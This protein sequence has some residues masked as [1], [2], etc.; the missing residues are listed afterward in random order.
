MLLFRIEQTGITL[1]LWSGARDGEGWRN[2]RRLDSNPAPQICWPSLTEHTAP[3][4]NTVEPWEHKSLKLCVQIKPC[5]NCSMRCWSSLRIEATNSFEKAWWHTFMQSLQTQTDRQRKTDTTKMQ[6]G[7]CPLLQHLVSG[8]FSMKHT[9]DAYKPKRQHLD[10]PIVQGS[11]TEE[12]ILKISM[13]CCPNL[14]IIR[15][16]VCHLPCLLV[17]SD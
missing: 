17:L 11:L 3:Q 8:L 6:M 13:A 9:L 16:Y 14:D 15:I 12:I 5:K 2:G 4:N 7:H 10:N 1:S